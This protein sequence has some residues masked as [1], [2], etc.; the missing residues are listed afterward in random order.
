MQI[1]HTDAPIIEVQHLYKDFPV[2]SNAIKSG[3]MRA[4]SDITFNLHRGRALAVVG[5]S[6]SGKSTIAKIIAKMYKLSNGRIL[7][8]GRDLEE[9]NKGTALL[10]YR[11]SVQMVWQDPFGSLNPTHT[12]YHHIARPLLLHSKVSD[13]RDL[14]DMVYG[15]LEKVGLTPAKATAAKYPHQLSGGQ[16]Q[17]VNIAR[18]LAVEAEVVLADEP[19]SMLDVSIRIGI[20]NLMEQMKNELGVSMLYIT[21]DIATARYVAE[22]LAVMYVG[23][24]VEWG[25][26]DEILHHPQHPY[27]QLLIS[28]VPDPEKSIHTELEGGRKG[29]IPLWTPESRGCPFAGRCHQAMPRCKESLPPVTR[30][31]D[32]HFVRC[33]LH[34]QG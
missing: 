33:Y 9:F 28:A 12:I 20:L 29:E 3:K 34:E 11:Q 30:L 22:D 14:S 27:T 4:L 26:V 24:M 19:T 21:H 10:D 31:A 23:H 17:R 1:A 13:K 6:G 7:Y 5:E 15:L 25:E 32:N 8:R 16:R 18:N 2:N